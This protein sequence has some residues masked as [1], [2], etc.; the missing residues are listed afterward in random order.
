M[1]GGQFGDRSPDR[2]GDRELWDPLRG[3]VRGPEAEDPHCRIVALL[4]SAYCGVC[5]TMVE[6][7]FGASIAYDMVTGPSSS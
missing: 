2:V 1:I 4:T 5:R 3:T 7:H 6:R